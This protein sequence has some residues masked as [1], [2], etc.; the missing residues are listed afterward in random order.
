MEYGDDLCS[1][2][3]I[4]MH[5]ADCK[6]ICTIAATV[7]ATNRTPHNLFLPAFFLSASTFLKGNPLVLLSAPVRLLILPAELP[8]S[9]HHKPIAAKKL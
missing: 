9:T 5:I 6:T 8:N 4:V 1:I 3:Q 7:A 2:D